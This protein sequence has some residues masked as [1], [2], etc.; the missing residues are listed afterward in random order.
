MR[1]ELSKFAMK[2]LFGI[3]VLLL[4][5]AMSGCVT[6]SKATA[7]A[8]QAYLAGQK[9]ALS[10]LPGVVVVL[11]DVEIHQVPWVEGLTLAQAIATAKYNGLHDPKDILLRRQGEEG[12]VNAKDLLRGTDVPLEP[13]DIITVNEH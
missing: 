12:R 11:G 9:D 2:V 8:R 4:A 10:N 5:A 13:G 3:L 6:K 7:M 1:F